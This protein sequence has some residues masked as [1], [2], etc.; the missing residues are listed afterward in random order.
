MHRS[1]WIL[2]FAAVLQA[3]DAVKPKA[4]QVPKA[5][6]IDVGAVLRKSKDFAAQ[7][8]AV[9][10]RFADGVV[11]AEG[12]I[13]YRGGGPCEYLINIFPAKP[14]E[15]VVLLDGG[16]PPKRQVARESLKGYGTTL[17]SA[18][19]A[20]GFKRGKPFSWNDE[21]GEVFPPTGDAVHLYVEWQDAKSGENKRALMS[22]WLWNFRTTHTMQPDFVYTGSTFYEIDDKKFFAADVDGLLVAVLNNGAALV[23]N[24][25]DGSL[26]NGVYEAIPIRMPPIETR[27]T[28]VFSKKP[29]DGCE[30]Y[31]PLKLPPELVKARADYLAR[32]A[33]GEGKSDAGKAIEERKKADERSKGPKKEKESEPK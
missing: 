24:R 26:D 17:N 1:L 14:H 12:E 8:A 19:L 16:A 21:T 27:V 15:T 29:L 13:A 20:A 32:K 7:C 3:D 31:P 5:P 6:S 18:L 30:K 11:R 2:V 10:I 33:K 23:D 25:E 4:P 28:V 9:K 22:D